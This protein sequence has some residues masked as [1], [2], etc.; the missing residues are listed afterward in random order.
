MYVKGF[1]G[2]MTSGGLPHL[3]HLT[4]GVG[5]PEVMRHWKRALEPDEMVCRGWG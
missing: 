4:V 1:G 5:M 3:D 2:D